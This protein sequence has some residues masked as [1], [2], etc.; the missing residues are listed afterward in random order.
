MEAWRTKT[1]LG[2]GGRKAAGQLRGSRQGLFFVLWYLKVGGSVAH[3]FLQ[4]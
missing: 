1:S 2:K 3:G 4:R